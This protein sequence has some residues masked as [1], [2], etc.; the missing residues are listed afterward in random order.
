[1]S[2]EFTYIDKYFRPLTESLEENSFGLQDD[3][4]LLPEKSETEDFVVNLDNALES[5]HFFTDSSPETIAN[6][7]I[8][9][10]I[11]DIIAKGAIP[12]YYFLSLTAGSIVTE[13]WLERFTKRLEALQ[14][15]YSITLLGGDT[16]NIARPGEVSK[17]ILSITMIG[18]VEKW[19]MIRRGSSAIGDLICVSGTIGRGY[20]GYNAVK[21][22]EEKYQ[23]Y[24]NFPS[25]DLEISKHLT[26]FATSSIDVSDGLVADLKH[27]LN[28]EV[29][30]E[31]YLDRIPFASEEECNLEEQKSMI[32][33]GDDYRILF[34]IPSDKIDLLLPHANATIIGKIIPG[35]KEVKVY[36]DEKLQ[37]EITLE[38]AGYQHF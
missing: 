1:M 16:S 18:T 11:S 32:S 36:R 35:H 15:I 10:N 17:T 13:E 28:P 9:R 30:A 38:T 8:V 37:E 22:N 20:L 27:L 26:E 31:I 24:Y 3:V 19:E 6:R 14:D 4:A 34:T 23:K 2:K 12:K 33:W 5:V 21:N 7:I 29:S 25:L